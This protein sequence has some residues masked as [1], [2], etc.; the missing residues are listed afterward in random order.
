MAGLES[1]PPCEPETRYPRDNGFLYLWL[2]A[3]V[4]RSLVD[5][6]PPHCL[7]GQLL[8]Q[9]AE[10]LLFEYGHKGQVAVLLVK[11]KAVTEHELV[12][13]VKADIVQR[14]I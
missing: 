10:I 13:D 11:V 12:R 8:G 7:P 1:R 14:H 9:A 5:G 4:C 3:F 2:V 6:T